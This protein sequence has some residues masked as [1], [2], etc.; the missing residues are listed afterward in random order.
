MIYKG[1]SQKE[2][3]KLYLEKGPN[4]IPNSREFSLLRSILEA[5]KEPMTLI[6]LSA[7][8]IYFVIG[9]SLDYIILTV[10]ALVIV[11]INVYQNYKSEEALEKLKDF[12]KKY[13]EVFRD[14]EK[15]TIESKYLV[16]GDYVI[17]NEGDRVPADILIV[18][19]SNLLI[20]ESIL[21]GESVPIRKKTIKDINLKKFTDDYIA[22]SG[23]LITSG[24]MIGSVYKTG[25]NSKIGELGKRLELIKD[26]E[27][28][29]K[30]EINKIVFNLAILCVF[31]CAFIFSYNYYQTS[32][33]QN[34][35]IYSI[36]I[37]IALVPEELPIVLTIFLALSSLRL[38]NKG[39]IIKNKAI[40][41]TLGSANIICVDKTGTITKN[42][43]KLKKIIYQDQDLDFER[44]ELNQ[45]I[46]RLLRA[47]YL[48]KYFNSKDALDIEI[49]KIFS[50]T[51]IDISEFNSKE[52]GVLDRRF[53]YSKKYT[54]GKESYI[55]AKG[56]YEEISKICRIPSKYEDFM[57]DKIQ[58]LT[59]VGYRIIAVA[60]LKTEREASS[61]KFELL[62]LLAFHDELRDETKEYVELCQNNKLRV[63]MITGDHKNTA[64]F[65]ANEIGLNNPQNVLTGDEL[66]KLPDHKLREL[67]A[68]T[69]VYA[70]IQPQ[71]KLKLV[72]FLK[73]RGNIVVMTGD[74]VN[75]SLALKAAN[76]GISIGEGG[77]DIAK[78]TSDIILI[79]N[80][81][82][83]IIEGI[84]EGRRI[85]RNLGITARYIYSFHLPIILISIF[86]TFF[87][88]PFLLLPVH[89]AFLEFIIDPFSTIVFESIPA[90]KNILAQTPR[91][92]NF[93]L[94]ENMKIGVGTIYGVAMF[95]LIFIPYYLINSFDPES[96]KTVAI[97]NL[98]ILN[99]FLIYFNF[100]EEQ[101][102]F[103]VLKDRTFMIAITIISLITLGIYLIRDRLNSIG[104]GGSI[105][106]AEY[107]LLGGSV[108]LFV[109]VGFFSKTFSKKAS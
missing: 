46:K 106:E 74:G 44:I 18:E 12:T 99:I 95:F 2:A 35:I 108:L 21:T 10:S 43:E 40:I 17:V 79:K 54:K 58:E 56:A 47:S 6:L 101:T 34:S 107:L 32:N 81:L 22:F 90:Q 14:G 15:I 76:I 100:S 64:I 70:R 28:Q 92:A 29:V 51:G 13:C 31:T 66:E 65:Y 55:F 86:N 103:Q 9:R 87:Q 67:I 8:V 105:S 72:N 60:E 30:K 5:L 27:P 91:K 52:E 62:G 20:N 57:L 97:L 82:K 49:E 73:S 69:N 26:E 98:M 63:C 75:D 4:E 38:S 42:N 48:S 37:A 25:I 36:S 23:A 68:R 59:N 80:D 102:F 19:S 61:K 83:S 3:Q 24:W 109:F 84:K 94:I 96:A 85:Y 78:E 50:K 7:C 33:I 1:L 16:E 77:T 53:V 41:E 88:L 39:L 11:S 104:L 71:Q 89:I 45:D 93:K